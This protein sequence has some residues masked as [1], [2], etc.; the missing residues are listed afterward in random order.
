MPLSRRMVRTWPVAFMLVASV[1]LVLASSLPAQAQGLSL[2]GLAG[3]GGGGDG[4]Q[5][6]QVDPQALQ[7]S[8]D[9]VIATLE[10]DA[11]RGELLT[12]LKELRQATETLTSETGAGQ[13]GQGGLLGALADSFTEYGDQ[14]QAG[15]APL[16][17]W[18]QRTLRASE[19]LEALFS[20]ISR[21]ELLRD[22]AEAAVLLAVWSGLLFTLIG[23][24]RLLARRHGW[25]RVLPPEPRGWMLIEH[26]LRKALPWM[27][28]FAI[29]LAVLSWLD[30]SQAARTIVL[31]VAYITMCGRLLST[32][33]DV[34]ISLFT[35]GHRRVAVAIL[36]QG[37]LG[38]LFLIGALA[39]LGDA[40][41]SERLSAQ[42]GNELAG[43]VSVTCNVLAAIIS[44][45]LVI[46]YRRP[47][48]HLI[49]NRPYPQRREKTTSQEIINVIGRLWHVPALLLIGASLLAIFFSAGEADGAFTRA[50]VCAAL[51]VLT[52]VINGVI[53]RHSEKATH[54]RRKSQYRRRLERFGYTLL[55]FVF[56]AIFAELSLRVWGLSFL[57][58]GEEGAISARIGQAL[59]G[60]GTTVLLAWLAWIFADTAIQRAL[61]AS[62]RSRGRRVHS[63]RAQTITPMIRNAIFITIVVIALIVGLAN[64]GVNV[65]PLLAGAGVIGLA[66]GFGAQT[67]VQDLITGL[68]ILI[69]DSLT[70]DDF[71]DVG[72]HMGT[73]ERLSLRTVR[74]RDLDGIVHIIP[75]SQIK[76]IQNFSREFGIALMRIHIPHDMKIDEAIELMRSVADDL[77]KDPMMRH[78]VWSPLEVQGIQAFEQGTALLRIRMRT[79]P[80]MQWDVARA[81]NLRLKQRLDELGQS[82]AVPR[83]SVTME[84]AEPGGEFHETR[85]DASQGPATPRRHA[86]MPGVQG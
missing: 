76:G 37:A 50:I 16:D 81:F 8:L 34:V 19:D 33:F 54:R 4:E 24:G 44:G 9:Q 39:A 84:N 86:S 23:A 71:V 14:A 25:P 52:L 47:A 61:N 17:I 55:Y 57:G 2:S 65:T 21:E 82:L 29:M 83:M 58:I 62:A 12:R 64:L 70:I 7:A 74:L 43:W 60:V 48:K 13:S 68:F 69:E 6:T 10:N 51:L 72:G 78:Y 36:R 41:S 38:R 77:R 67:L 46:R 26:F 63:A 31:V 40:A 45:G 11:Q 22:S 73:V 85:D 59:L 79:A 66:I 30:V 20:S 35:R 42:M 49:R 75:F 27:L 18:T 80:V 28:A 1:L 15:Q 56:W 53:Q 5:Q 3:G 32:V